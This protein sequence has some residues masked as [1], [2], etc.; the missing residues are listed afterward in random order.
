MQLSLHHFP[1]TKSK[2][3][4]LPRQFTQCFAANCVRAG[5]VKVKLWSKIKSFFGLFLRAVSA[6]GILVRTLEKLLWVRLE[7]H[8][9]QHI[10]SESGQKQMS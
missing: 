6:A 10:I 7:V 4:F 9:A 3:S 8:L 2:L 1:Q 5:T